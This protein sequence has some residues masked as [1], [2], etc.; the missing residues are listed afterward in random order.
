[1][2]HIVVHVDASVNDIGAD[3]LASRAVIDVLGAARLLVRDSAKTPLSV[4]LG[5]GGADLDD[6]ILLD[7]LDLS[8]EFSISSDSNAENSPVVGEPNLHQGG[9]GGPQ[10]QN[11]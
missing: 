5:G 11:H 4:G 6:S 8:L 9:P 1:M 3:I 2:T 7:K 10:A